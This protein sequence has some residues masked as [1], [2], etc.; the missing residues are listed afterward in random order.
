M[1]PGEHRQAVPNSRLARRTGS[2][3][4]AVRPRMLQEEDAGEGG[5]HLPFAP[6]AHSPAQSFDQDEVFA[7][8]DRAGPLPAA[9][10]ASAQFWQDA[11]RVVR[12]AV[13]RCQVEIDY[14]AIAVI[15]R[16]WRRFRG[17]ERCAWQPPGSRATAWLAGAGR[18]GGKARRFAGKLRSVATLAGGGPSR[19][20]KTCRLGPPLVR[21]VA[22]V[23]S[24]HG[25]S[26]AVRVSSLV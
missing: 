5:S 2:H 8:A 23:G 3:A 15:E 22:A 11:E 21:A 20:A 7:V 24:G 13:G 14:R 25:A 17:V 6:P 26:S 16:A 4:D 12:A 10:F 19:K 1:Q 9:S 18:L